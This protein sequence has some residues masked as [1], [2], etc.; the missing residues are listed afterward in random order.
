M[1]T[2]KL[3][4]GFLIW[5]VVQFVLSKFMQM[6]FVTK[7]DRLMCGAS[8][9]LLLSIVGYFF[10]VFR[11][12]VSA[13]YTYVFLT[14]AS[15]TA[16]F[17]M[18]SMLR[19]P[20]FLP[21]TDDRC[22]SL[23]HQTRPYLF[24]LFLCFRFDLIARIVTSHDGGGVHQHPSPMRLCTT[25]LIDRSRASLHCS[26]RPNS[27]NVLLMYCVLISYYCFFCLLPRVVMCASST[28]TTTVLSLTIAWGG[29]IVGHSLSSSPVHPPL[30]LCLY[31][32]RS[33]PRSLLNARTRVTW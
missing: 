24:F 7:T 15:L 9:G 27:C 31:S 2:Y 5:M 12:I 23:R 3:F 33:M 1:F 17:F 4:Y 26:V 6:S 29:E 18:L 10:S 21:R 19:R 22:A 25:C 14:G 8:W 30:A 16:L 13:S 20:L 32:P 11:P 28:W